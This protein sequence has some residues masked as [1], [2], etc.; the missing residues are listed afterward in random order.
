MLV[1]A[2]GS[3]AILVFALSLLAAL[4]ALVVIGD[5]PGFT[6]FILAALVLRLPCVRR[7]D[8][9]LV[10]VVK[11]GRHCT[12]QCVVLTFDLAFVSTSLG[13]FCPLRGGGGPC[14][15]ELVA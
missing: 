10:A 5:T 9:F 12:E 14:L 8:L 3:G 1:P 13:I 4:C 11:A 6:F 15:P 2:V 7:V